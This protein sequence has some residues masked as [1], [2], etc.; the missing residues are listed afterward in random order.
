MI[1]T[2]QIT[3]LDN[4]MFAT[5]H[6]IATILNKRW[7]L[8]NCYKIKNELSQLVTLKFNEVQEELWAYCA[9]KKHRGINLIIDKARKEGVSTYWLLYYLDD[10]MWTPNTTTCIVAHTKSD[11]QK[12]FKIVKLAYKHCP[13][14]LALKSG[15]VWYKPN[16]SYDNVNELTFGEINS[17]IYV[18]LENRGDTINNL[19]ISEAAHKKDSDQIITTMAAQPENSRSNTTV[20]STANGVGDWFEETWGDCVAGNG[21]FKPFFFGWWRK[22]LNRI[23]PPKDYLPSQESLL[24]AEMVMTEYGVKLDKAQLFWWDTTKAKQRKLMDQENPTVPTDSF[25]TSVGMVF[26]TDAMKRF[27]PVEPPAKLPIRIMTA[28]GKIELYHVDIYVK[29]NPKRRYVVGGDPAEGVGG[30][31]SAAEV[32][33]DLTLEQV[34]E[35][36]SNTI[37]PG[38]FATLLAYLGRYYNNALLAPELNNHGHLVIDRL[39]NTEKYGNIFVRMVFDE[40][41]NKKTRK[42]G[43]ETNS[44]TR[45]LILDEFENLFAELSLKLNSAKIKSQMLTFITDDT[46]KRQAKQGK[47]DDLILAFA[48]ALKVARMPRASFEV[49][50]Q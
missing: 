28:E 2:R 18:A 21:P 3:R 48:I 17:T 36:S 22:K 50:R 20:E 14:K 9:K 46:G 43:W 42:L 32:I 30:D 38:N 19:H 34:A 7:R 13:N 4:E 23:E 35:F 16:A 1:I 45:D 26:D 39:K 31:E 6:D 8:E 10:T 15:K 11:V 41:K 33:D 44:K 27:N 29:P 25:L 37:K 12:L 49:F 24:K 47:K 40:K 5:K